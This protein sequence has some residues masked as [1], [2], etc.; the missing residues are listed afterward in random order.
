MLS[1]SQVFDVKH[2]KMSITMLGCNAHAWLPV[3]VPAHAHNML[4]RL[5]LSIMS[6]CS[7]DTACQVEA[8]EEVERAF[9]HVDYLRRSEPEHKVD[10]NLRHQRQNLLEPHD[11]LASGSLSGPLHSGKSNGEASGSLHGPRHS[12]KSNDDGDKSEQ[13]VHSAPNDAGDMV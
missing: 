11:S 13:K 3:L 1:P 2:K 6:C 10:Y 8:F 5:D 9:V 4:G 12:E 7:C